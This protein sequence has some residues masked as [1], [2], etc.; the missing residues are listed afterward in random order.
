MVYI[1]TEQIG[2]TAS[3]RIGRK[4]HVKETVV[5]V[6]GRIGDL[7]AIERL[8]PRNIVNGLWFDYTATF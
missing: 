1:L 4:G 6:I 5:D 2:G 8:E 7:I 3:R